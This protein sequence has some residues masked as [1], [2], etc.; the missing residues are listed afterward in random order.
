MHYA[1]QEQS[2]FKGHQQTRLLGF[3]SVKE[4]TDFINKRTISQMDT[5][6]KVI[7]RSELTKKEINTFKLFAQDGSTSDGIVVYSVILYR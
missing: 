5:Q 6:Y 2:W 3:R 7:L 1:I 4:R